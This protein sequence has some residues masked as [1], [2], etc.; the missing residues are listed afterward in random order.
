[1]NELIN[2]RHIGIEQFAEELKSKYKTRIIKPIY[3]NQ[4]IIL[5]LFTGNVYI[6]KTETGNFKINFAIPNFWILISLILDMAIFLLLKDLAFKN[7]L[8]SI[9]IFIIIFFLIIYS[10]Y[11]FYYI[12]HKKIKEYI[13]QILK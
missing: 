3:G 6:H 5:N 12:K 1:M 11:I 4:F 2:F 7:I 10:Y 13:L 8:I 9:I